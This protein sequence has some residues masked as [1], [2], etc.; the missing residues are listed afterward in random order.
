MGLSVTDAMRIFLKR[1]VVGLS[2]GTQGTNAT[3][4]AATAEVD[5]IAAAAMSQTLSF[6]PCAIE[7]PR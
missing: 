4:R 3:T 7:G 2:A 1:V 5:D 6:S